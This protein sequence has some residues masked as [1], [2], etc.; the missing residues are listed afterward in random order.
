MLP[1]IERLLKQRTAPDRHHVS[2]LVLSPTRELAQ[3][4]AKESVSIVAGRRSIEVQC[5]VGGTNMQTE[6]ARFDKN[7]ID[8]LVATPDRLIDHI[9]DSNLGPRFKFLQCLVLDEADRLLDQ[10]FMPAIQTIL[11]SLPDRNTR[12]R[13]TLLFSATLPEKVK[14]L[15]SAALLPTYRYISTISETEQST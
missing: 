13:Q 9:R 10:G 8:I 3:H 7:R 15:S 11:G 5:V 6:A 1:A 14:M 4:I 2:I 12:P